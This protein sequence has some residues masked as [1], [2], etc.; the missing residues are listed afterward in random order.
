MLERG[1][2]VSARATNV[3]RHKKTAATNVAHGARPDLIRG[4]PSNRIGVMALSR[5]EQE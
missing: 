5:R 2:T 4:R 3:K 1:S